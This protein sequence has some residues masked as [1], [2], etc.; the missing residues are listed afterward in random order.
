MSQKLKKYS[1]YLIKEMIPVILGILIALYI[2]N[3]NE[4]RKDTRYINHILT[5][6]NNDL[7]ETKTSIDSNF[8]DQQSILDTLDFYMEDDQ[9]S[10]ADI[11]MKVNGFQLPIIRLNTW[12][13]ISN[14]KIELIDYEK[15]VVLSQLEEINEAL[16][17][18]TQYLLNF[19][20]T[21]L[22]SSEKSKKLTLH[23]LL[24]D[25]QSNINDIE[26]GIIEYEKTVH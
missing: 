11:G 21:N 20:Y 23:L 10:I 17:M 2:N 26:G 5:S 3:W 22:D 12:K 13:A 7:A 14:S 6:I 15:V 24:K 25:I 8:S 19:V 18:K 16:K 9:I 1:G 4:N